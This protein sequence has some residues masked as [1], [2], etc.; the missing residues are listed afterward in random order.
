[1]TAWT[2]VWQV[3]IDGGTF[4]TVTLANLSVASGRTDIYQQPVAG[5]CTV[6]LINTNGADFSIDVNN[7]F[8]LQVKNTSGTFTAIFGGYVTDIDQSVKSSGASAIVQSFRITALGALSKLP[9]ILTNGVLSKDFDGDQIYSILEPVFRNSWNEVAPALTWAAYTPATETWANAQNVGLGEIDQ[10][11]DYELTARSSSEIDVYSLISGLAISGL[12]YIYEDAQGRICYA[13]ATHRSQY[14]ASNGYTEVSANH[15]LSKG[16]ATS[17]RIGD[18]RNKVSI[19]HKNGGIAT[20]QDDTSIAIYGQQAQ[21]ITTSIENTV[22]AES[23]ADFYLALR[24]YPQSLFKSIT[25]ELTNPEIDDADRDALI[26][27]FMGLPLYITDLPANLAGGSFEGFVEGW[28]FNAGF[29]KLSVT[30]NLSPVAFSMQF[31]KWLDVGAAET[32]NTLNPTL[33][34]IDATIVA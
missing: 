5:Y 19:T 22:D 27:V 20:A 4:T 2:P 31:M 6:E 24:A 17:R 14:L 28:S 26:G 29:N 10:P 25:F 13:D 30:L 23:Q 15:A 1:M 32:W 9:K 8:T 3:S 11:G 33:E 34:W 7:S 21:N 18:I 16:I 12:G